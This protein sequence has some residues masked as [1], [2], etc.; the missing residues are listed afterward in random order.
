MSEES[1]SKHILELAKELLDDIELNRLNAENLLLK[2]TRLARY[3]GSKEIN[4]WLQYEMRG[5]SSSQELSLKYVGLTGRWVD[6]TKGEA[7]W[8]PL[9]QIEAYIETEKVRLQAMRIPN[10]SGDYA[11]I[12]INNVT[13]AM[14]SITQCIAKVSGIKSRVLARLHQFITEVYY[15]RM[16]DNLAENI[17]EVFKNDT[18]AVIAEKCGDIIEQI[19]SVMDRLSDGDQESI[20]QALTTCRRIIDAFADNI[21]PPTDET[22]ELNGNTVSLKADKALNRINA[23]IHEKCESD[24]RRKKIRQNLSNTYDRV[25]T[26]VHNQI[27]AKEARALFLNTY[28]LLGEILSL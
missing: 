4:K 28:L 20:S 6:K 5:Y 11:S 18:D 19:P 9:A 27:D 17:F 16:F 2:V 8:G 12:T 3:T 10:V 26:G 13:N 1:R 14:S 15:E 25:C 7:Y 22:I 21:Y 24:S 23:Y